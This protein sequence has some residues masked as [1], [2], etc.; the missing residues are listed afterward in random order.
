MPCVAV[1]LQRSLGSLVGKAAV[2]PYSNAQTLGA[3]LHWFTL[4]PADARAAMVRNHLAQAARPSSR[5]ETGRPTGAS[6]V[7]RSPATDA[8]ILEI[9][10]IEDDADSVP[11]PRDVAR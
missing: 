10:R 3:I 11:P 7:A 5:A 2:K 8:R 6:K 9:P 1:S 4:L